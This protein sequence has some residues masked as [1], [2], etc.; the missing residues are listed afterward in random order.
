MINIKP[1]E[2]YLVIEQLLSGYKDDD[3]NLYVAGQGAVGGYLSKYIDADSRKMQ[4]VV[5]AM[6]LM[7]LF[8]AFRRP[9]GL[10]VPLVVI[11]ASAVGAIGIM[12][13]LDVSYF[14]I[15]SALPVVITAI[16]VA[17]SIHV[18][19]AYYEQ[20]AR[21]P[22]ADKREHIMAAMVDMANPIT[23]TT[24]T[25]IA[26]FLGLAFASIMPP[27]T[28]FGF[29]A[30]LGVAIAWTFTM[31]VLP[32]LMML[33][34]MPQSAVFDIHKQETRRNI[35]GEILANIA[36]KVTQNP[37]H[38]LFG[39]TV[40]FIVALSGALQLKVDRAQVEN[41]QPDEPIRLAH[42]HINNKYAGSAY[43]D[44]LLEAPEQDGLLETQAINEALDIQAFLDT[45]P[46]VNKSLS[47][48]DYIGQIHSAMGESAAITTIPRDPDLIAQYLLLYESSAGQEDFSD[49]IDNQYQQM[50][51]RAYLN[52]D[53][54]SEEKEVVEAVV[55]Y[56]E[57]RSEGAYLSAEISGRVNV[58]YHWMSRLGDSH[59]KSI[60]FSL[61]LVLAISA[62]LFRSLSLGV[63]S[64]LPV[65]Y[66]IVVVYGVMGWTGTFL[67]AGD[68]NVCCHCNRCWY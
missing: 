25:T 15:T 58:D 61:V 51:I 31:L 54:F 14:A 13:W 52:S 7:L 33:M 9:S 44:I 36:Q 59:F 46:H 32:S 1:N 24:L 35:S 18:L 37:K 57:G 30:A 22:E 68:V 56:L 4:P 17:D 55:K 3:I 21:F 64:L 53:Y 23:L 63:V 43:L 19:T 8:L 38:T 66:S 42:Q 50:L 39:L 45:L 47:I 40:V 28:Y 11:I 16:A 27:V 48:F 10:V 62:L 41:F 12:G 5:V 67:R 2:T 26:G 65:L 49:E 20:K 6:I 29:F 60:G 34:K